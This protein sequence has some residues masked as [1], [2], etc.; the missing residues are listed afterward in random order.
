MEVAELLF[1]QAC[2][3]A[4]EAGLHLEN[5]GTMVYTPEEIKERRG[6]FWTLYILDKNLSLVKGRSHYISL[7]GSSI[8]LPASNG[9][10]SESTLELFFLARIRLAMIQ[11]QVF[12]KLYS[13]NEIKRQQQSV[14]SITVL[15]SLLR[16]W[17]D[18]HK[19]LLDKAFLN[20]SHSALS[21]EI[22]FHYQNT[23]IL[24]LRCFDEISYQAA[25]VGPC[26]ES[27][28]LLQ[29]LNQSRGVGRNSSLL[30]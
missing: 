16:H 15:D 23:R 7:Q 3:L 1:E 10:N 26:R 27:L 19:A 13:A 2:Q 17:Y 14:N 11:E 28:M 18:E 22:L 8:P 12:L 30:R 9:T 29:N 6:L 25:C 24:V 4:L 21:L 20:G 5:D